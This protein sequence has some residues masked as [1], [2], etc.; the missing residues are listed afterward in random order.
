VFKLKS[1]KKVAVMEFERFNFKALE[2]VK[3]KAGD[4]GV[5]LSLSDPAARAI[6]RPI[7]CTALAKEIL[8]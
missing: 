4:L 6:T 3:K 1:L 2:D 8:Q 5:S 7:G